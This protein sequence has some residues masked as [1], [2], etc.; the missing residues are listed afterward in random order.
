MLISAC[1]FYTWRRKC[2]QIVLPQST[3]YQMVNTSPAPWRCDL[4]RCDLCR[5]R[6]PGWIECSVVTVLKRVVIFEQG[7]P[8]CS[9]STQPCFRAD[10]CCC[11]VWMVCCTYKWVK[12][13]WV[14][15]PDLQTPSSSIS[16]KYCIV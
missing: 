4:W 13:S 11:S 12:H 2:S 6:A 5:H 15:L 9:S 3:A 7:D 10:R 16:P 8:T 14:G 1:L